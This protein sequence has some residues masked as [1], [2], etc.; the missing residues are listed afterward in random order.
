MQMFCHGSWCESSGNLC[1][2]MFR[3]LWKRAVHIYNNNILLYLPNYIQKNNFILIYSPIICP[4][5]VLFNLSTDESMHI[6][7][8]GC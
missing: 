2:L 7:A 4:E 6:Y 5:I 1:A 8:T 3:T